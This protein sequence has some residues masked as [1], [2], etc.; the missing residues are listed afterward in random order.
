MA[1]LLCQIEAV[2]NSRPLYI[3]GDNIEDNEVLTPGHFLIGRPPL[4]VFE[5]IQDNEKIGSLDKW[6]L[7]QEMKRNCWM[8]WKDEYLYTLQEGY[9]WKKGVPNIE[10]GQ[11]VLLKHENCHPTRWPMGKVEEVHKGKD[12]KVRV[13]K[14]KTKEASFTRP[15]TKIFPLI[16]VKKAEDVMEKAV[17]N[18]KEYHQDFLN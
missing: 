8:K 12:D 9:K 7:I 16:G 3:T 5:S 4:D 11:V 13:V 6:K 10:K 15:I 18:K 14:V 2:L 1:T 17:K